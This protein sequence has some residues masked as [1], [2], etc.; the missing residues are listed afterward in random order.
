VIPLIKRR[1]V[2]HDVKT[3]ARFSTP[4]QVW[5]QPAYWPGGVRRRGGASLVWAPVRNVRTSARMQ[6]RAGAYHVR[7]TLKREKPQEAEYRCRGAGAD[8]PVV[9]EKPG[10][11]GGATGASYPGPFGGQPTVGKSR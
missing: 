10:N 6:W 5:R 11:A 3:G 1:E 4:G 8:R 7:E 9:A 2:E